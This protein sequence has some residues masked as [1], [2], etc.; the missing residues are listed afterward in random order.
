[1][2]TLDRKS[3]KIVTLNPLLSQNKQKSITLN[4]K[5]GNYYFKSTVKVKLAKIITLD[6]KSKKIVTLNLLLSQNWQKL[7]L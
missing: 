7:L 6:R 2:I 1:M 5:I 4:R 3:K